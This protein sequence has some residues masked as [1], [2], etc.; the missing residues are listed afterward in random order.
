MSHSLKFSL[1][2]VASGLLVACNQTSP[3][4]PS[5]LPSPTLSAG[6]RPGVPAGASL[7]LAAGTLPAGVVLPSDPIL[8]LAAGSIDFGDVL[9]NTSVTRDHTLTVPAGLQVAAATG[10]GIN[11]PYA[12]AF[13]TCAGF[14]GPGVCNIKETFHPTA[15]GTFTATL[16]VFACPSVGI[17]TPLEVALTGNGV[18]TLP[19]DLAVSIQGAEKP[20]PGPKPVT[21]VIT[22]QNFGPSNAT[23]VAVD[24]VLPSGS[25]FVSASASQG[26]CTTPPVGATGTMSCALG[27]LANGSTASITVTL[28]S[29]VKKLAL[30]DTATVSADATIEDPNPA[31]NTATAVV[32]VK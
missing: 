21:F 16:N 25:Q 15:V 30:E 14:T 4:S 6:V 32:Q 22:V 13:D 24:N 23:G 10:G 2:L 17:C 29:S 5:R 9:V 8:N 12:F 20:V 26:S 11:P 19:A 27:S 18:L 1:A 3:T 7:K 31:N 28:E